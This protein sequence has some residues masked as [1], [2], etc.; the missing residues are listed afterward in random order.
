[1]IRSN[2]KLVKAQIKTEVEGIHRVNEQ[3]TQK[4]FGKEVKQLTGGYSSTMATGSSSS[5]DDNDIR[6]TYM[7]RN[8]K[9]FNQVRS[10]YQKSG[11]DISSDDKLEV[12]KNTYQ[13]EQQYP[14]HVDSLNTKAQV[15]KPSD[16]L[17]SDEI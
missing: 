12:I 5:G 13:K 9:M 4:I 16:P 8:D 11:Q 2:K 17:L 3:L 6:L 14:E 1:M 15:T 7:G 10:V